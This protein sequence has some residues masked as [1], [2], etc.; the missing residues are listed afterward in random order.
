MEECEKIAAL[1][2]VDL[3]FVGPSDLSQ[4][5]GVLAQW[6]SEKL[7]TA[8]ERVAA[9]CKKHSKNWARSPSTR[10]CSAG[11]RRRL[12]DAELRYGHCHDAAG[13]GGDARDV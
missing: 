13:I 8:M 10:V 5:L 4:V 11:L 1:D 6:E 2:G 9:A 7:W 3:L 12:P